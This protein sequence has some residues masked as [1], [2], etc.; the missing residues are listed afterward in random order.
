MAGPVFLLSPSRS[1]STVSIAL[2]SGHPRLFGFPETLLFLTPT[3]GELIEFC[4]REPAMRQ[5]EPAARNAALFRGSRLSGLARA[6]AQLHEGSQEEDAVSRSLEWLFDHRPWSSADVLDYLRRLISPQ[7]AIEKTPE[8]CY[9]DQ[10]LASCVSAYPDSRFLHLTRHPVT[11]RRSMDEA[12]EVWL[13]DAPPEISFRSACRNAGLLPAYNMTNWHSCH[14]RIIRAL[15]PLPRDRWMRVRAEDLLSAPRTWLPRILSW[16]RL[17]SSDLLIAHMMHTEN[18][19]FA[20]GR[21]GPRR[22]DG[23]W[24]FF[25]DPALRPVALPDSGLVDPEWH[26][27]SAGYERIAAL[28]GY[29][30]Y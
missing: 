17:E 6:I 9:S 18:W 4:A 10:A 30:G 11:W 5:V 15:E 7:I 22:K 29:L 26:I 2:L 24:K 1:Y 16:L 19:P 12:S 21:S 13:R 28:A 23:D 3:V 14:L 27:T 25:A 8:I 20:R